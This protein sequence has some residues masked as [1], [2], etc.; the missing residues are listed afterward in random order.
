LNWRIID[1]NFFMVQHRHPQRGPTRR[2]TTYTADI[3]GVPNIQEQWS[4]NWDTEIETVRWY[5]I[6][7]ISDNTTS[8]KPAKEEYHAKRMAMTYGRKTLSSMRKNTLRAVGEIDG[9]L[10]LIKAG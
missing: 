1:E 7:P 10:E 4:V 3:F 2:T 6:V 9:A 5:V 8:L